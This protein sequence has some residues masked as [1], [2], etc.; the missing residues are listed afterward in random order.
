MTESELKPGSLTPDPMSSIPLLFGGAMSTRGILGGITFELVEFI[1][2]I[3]H[4]NCSL[5]VDLIR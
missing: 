5:K 3:I 1:H 2:C 4:N